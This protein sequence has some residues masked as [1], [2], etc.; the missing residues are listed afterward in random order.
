MTCLDDIIRPLKILES[1]AVAEL[2][3][4]FKRFKQGVKPAYYVKC[5]AV[6][7]INHAYIGPYQVCVSQE[8][9]K[10]EVLKCKNGY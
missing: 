10:L 1:T 9:K 4:N 8:L 2:L 5:D 6:D 3:V 7:C